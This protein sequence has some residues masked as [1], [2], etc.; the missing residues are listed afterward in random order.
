MSTGAGGSVNVNLEMFKNFHL[1]A[2]SFWSDGGGRYIFGLGPDLIIRGDGTP[3]LVHSGSGIGGFEW[4]ATPRNMLYSYYGVGYFQRNVSV[5][6]VTGK[7]VGFGYSGS[8]SSANRAVQEP[9]FGYI[10]TLWKHENY[11]GLQVLTQYSYLTRSPWFVAPG[12]P[13]N[14]HASMVY[15]DFRY[16]IP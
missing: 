7:P 10:R 15:V 6:P 1:I 14:A 5:D 16:L 2:N 8:S 3:S 13:K 11:G 12:A 9:T 4:Q